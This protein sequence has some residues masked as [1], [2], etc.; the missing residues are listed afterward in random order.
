V[1]DQPLVESKGSPSILF[2]QMAERIEHNEG[3][4]F[5]GAVVIAPPGSESEPIT[6]LLLDPSQNEVH[7]WLT[8]QTKVQAALAVLEEAG[9]RQNS[10]F[11]RR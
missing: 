4:S 6:L 1:S 5:G 9:R 8:L 2:R 3:S 7:F 11:G 10:P